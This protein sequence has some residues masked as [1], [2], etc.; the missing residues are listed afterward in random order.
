[1]LYVAATRA[2]NR[3]WLTMTRPGP[4]KMGG[5]PENEEKQIFKELSMIRQVEESWDALKKRLVTR[6]IKHEE[7]EETSACSDVDQGKRGEGCWNRGGENGDFQRVK[8]F[9]TLQKY[10]EAV[11]PLCDDLDIREHRN[12]ERTSG[13]SLRRAVGIVVH[14]EIERVLMCTDS[15]EDG[16]RMYEDRKWKMQCRRDL[17]RAGARAENLCEGLEKVTNHLQKV[18]SDESYVMKLWI[19]NNGDRGWSLDFEREFDLGESW[20][21]SEDARKRPDLLVL[22]E[23]K[24]E[25]LVIDFKTGEEGK[26]DRVQV[27]N[28]RDIV[29]RARP[30]FVVDAALYYTGAGKLCL[31]ETGERGCGSVVGDIFGT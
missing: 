28:Y 1:M 11:K 15:P 7:Y 5:K 23:E 25:C 3:C 29:E 31:V 21:A 12:S 14:E 24:K 10:L 26:D 30:G 18:C 9:G 19:L 2:E 13:S 8:E 6:C 27:K 4:E 17:M 20:D 16:I 22:N